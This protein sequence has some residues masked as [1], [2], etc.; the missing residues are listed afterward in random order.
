[1]SLPPP[2]MIEELPR[3]PA[4]L[5]RHSTLPSRGSGSNRNH[6]S[7]TTREHHAPYLEQDLLQCK[8]IS[9]DEFMSKILEP[10]LPHGKSPSRIAQLPSVQKKFEA[11]KR[12]TNSDGDESRM[13]QPFVEL[14]N[15][16]LDK[17]GIRDRRFC[18]NDP[19]FVSG[20]FA[21]R[22]P[23]AAVVSTEAITGVT[24]RRSVENLAEKGPT[25]KPFHWGEWGVF[26][27][28]KEDIISET[29]PATS[30]STSQEKKPVHTKTPTQPSRQSAR[31]KPSNDPPALLD[32]E[33][34]EATPPSGVTI[35]TLLDKPEIQC[36]SYAAEILSYSR[37][38]KHVFGVLI[39]NL[40][41]ELQFY[42]R[43]SIIK[44]QPLNFT[45]DTDLV[46]FIKVLSALT[47]SIPGQWY[48]G[49]LNSDVP[50]VPTNNRSQGKTWKDLY[51]GCRMEGFPGWRFE[52][53]DLV[54][55]SHG[56]V[57]R[58]TVVVNADVLHGPVGRTGR[59]IVK[60]SW[61][62]QSRKSEAAFIKNA[63]EKA[64]QENP[65]M[66]YHLPDIYD[67][68]EPIS[69]FR[70][71]VFEGY[72]TR[73]LRITVQ[74]PLLPLHNSGLSPDQ[75]TKVFTDTVK[76]Y[77]WL[78]QKVGTQQGDITRNNLMFRRDPHN[79]E[80]LY[81]VIIDFDL[82]KDVNNPDASTSN[83]R[84]GTQ[85][86]MA[87]DLLAAEPPSRLYRHD[88]ESFM[89]VLA[90]L[91]CDINEELTDS[92][93]LAQW[94]YCRMDALRG[95]KRAVLEAGFPAVQPT[96]QSRD[97]ALC[98]HMWSKMFADGYNARDAY[99][100]EQRLLGGLSEAKRQKWLDKMA[101]MGS[102]TGFKPV[103]DQTLG[104]R[105]TFDNFE[106]A[107]ATI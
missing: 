2:P 90:F 5:T 51:T 8:F 52:L 63:R 73:V 37:L 97:F 60:W 55:Q 1:M 30:T 70:Q 68:A 45:T 31:T 12:A 48:P 46:D 76:A 95:H 33:L 20:S 71:I 62:A 3:F 36:A 10:N 107:L 38:R 24:L 53:S 21:K 29:I 7:L 106:D 22:K 14:A 96:F 58:G 92:P 54:F 56:L 103:D 91:V 94:R 49:L 11:F 82:A 43:S 9:L 85:P 6:D 87:L 42:D 44:S 67:Q 47:Q 61:S 99:Q 104:E 88:L 77:R 23:D 74:E 19:T 28:F 34:P 65:A 57:G 80:I 93:P 39:G 26:I 59:A 78:V 86:F 72:E 18:R 32:G 101:G 83:Q 41:M 102:G 100:K 79:P 17:L 50:P 66:L 13:Y 16:C 15:E 81:G 84:T 27:E 105:I 35:Q 98:L 4:L 40:S 75:L 69:A 64:L 89:Y 25:D